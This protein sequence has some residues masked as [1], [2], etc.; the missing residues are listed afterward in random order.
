M[1]DMA[2]IKVGGVV[3]LV[4]NKSIDL[5]LNTKCVVT[6]FY[7]GLDTLI[8]IKAIHNSFSTMVFAFRLHGVSNSINIKYSDGEY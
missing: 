3:I 8:E 1:R 7:R 4:D 5:P 6:G 2:K